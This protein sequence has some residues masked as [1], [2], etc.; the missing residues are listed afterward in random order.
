MRVLAIILAVLLAI[1]GVLFAVGYFA[2]PSAMTVTRSIDIARPRAG[3]YAILDNLRTFNEWSPWSGEDAQAEYTVEGEAGVGQTAKW[4]DKAGGGGGG[5]QII[6][7]S[8]DNQRVESDVNFGSLRGSVKT[9]WAV[10]K[11]PA[12]SRVTWSTASNCTANP[13]YVPCRYLN[14]MSKSAI[15]ADYDGGLARL[16]TLAEQLPVVDFES[17]QPEF[18]QATPLDYA[19][20]E[21]DVTRDEA[22]EGATPD[23]AAELDA[24]YSAR[25]STAIAESLAVVQSKLAESGATVSGPPVMVTVQADDDRMVFR[26]GYPYQGATPAADPRVATGHTPTGRALKFVHVGP[27]QAMRQ[28]YMMIGAY[29]VAHRIQTNGGPWEI[30]VQPNGDPATQRREIYIPI[31]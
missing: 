14:L 9:I 12:G 22:P 8:V 20:V 19:Y 31:R 1:A 2:L 21:N 17:L 15:E 16:K 5:V 29:L 18:L 28:T 3:V 27:V 13:I 23:A 6:T 26:A 25:V 7:R 11:A 24:T 10:E 4:I 30:H